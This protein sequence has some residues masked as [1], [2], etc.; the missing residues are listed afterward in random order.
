[1][2]GLVFLLATPA[3]GCAAHEEPVTK[4]EFE[5]RVVLRDAAGAEA[6][7]FGSGE[8]ITFEVTL[9]N[10]AAAPRTL[11][12]PTSQTHDCRV[13]GADH[14]EVWRLS[15]G[16]MFAQVI[17]ELTLKPGESRVFSATWDQTDTKGRPVPPGEYQAVGLVPGKV[18]GL[19]SDPVVFTI[20]PPAA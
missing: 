5:T 10:R 18:P 9:R 1:M 19:R 3:G 14:K 16:R 8:R 12:L 17:T 4:P 20:R 7:E 2:A 15:S 11:P 13:Y 6:R